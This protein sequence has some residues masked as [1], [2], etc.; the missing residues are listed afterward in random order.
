MSRAIS[1]RDLPSHSLIY[2]FCLRFCGSGRREDE[3]GTRLGT[4]VILLIYAIFKFVPRSFFRGG[5]A[6]DFFGELT[7]K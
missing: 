6:G 4:K 2:T 7:W 5:G 3:E 1:D